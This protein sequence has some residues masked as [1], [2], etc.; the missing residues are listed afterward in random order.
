MNSTTYL[1]FIAMACVMSLFIS[2]S[3]KIKYL[4]NKYEPTDDIKIYFEE[5]DIPED[6]EVMGR[7]YVK[8]KEDTNIEHIQ[9][10]IVA[11]VKSVGGDA[12]LMGELNEQVSGT[13]TGSAGGVTKVGKKSGVGSSVSKTKNQYKDKIECQVLKYK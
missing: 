4:G 11:K 9:R 2:C 7:I 12:V 3:T 1:R 8:F 5:T 6:N 13:V 10:S